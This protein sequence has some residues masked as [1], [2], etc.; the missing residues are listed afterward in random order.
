MALLIAL[1]MIGVIGTEIVRRFEIAAA[2]W[3]DVK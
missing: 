3:K 2:P 1:M